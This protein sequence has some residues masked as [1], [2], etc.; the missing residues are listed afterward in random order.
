MGICIVSEKQYSVQEPT[1]VFL[2]WHVEIRCTGTV[3]DVQEP[4][5]LRVHFVLALMPCVSPM[6]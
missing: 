4:I 3:Y 1:D 2:H 5:I 6:L